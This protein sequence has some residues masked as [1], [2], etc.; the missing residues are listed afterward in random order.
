MRGCVF[1]AAECRCRFHFTIYLG[2][3]IRHERPVGCGSVV[4]ARWV[5]GRKR[6]G[7][8]FVTRATLCGSGTN[9]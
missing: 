4:D 5:T 2:E 3:F 9:V 6:S 1:T 8:R 7:E